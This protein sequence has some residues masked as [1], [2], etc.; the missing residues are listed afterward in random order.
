[1]IYHYN[2]YNT[3]QHHYACIYH[4]IYGKLHG[5]AVGA[6]ISWYPTIISSYGPCLSMVICGQTWAD[7]TTPSIASLILYLVPPT[8]YA[9]LGWKIFGLYN[10]IAQVY[11]LSAVNC[12]ITRHS[13][14][15]TGYL[16]R[17][18]PNEIYLFWQKIGQTDCVFQIMLS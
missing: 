3:T 1:M 10:I 17:Y 12:Q 8:W 4:G 18:S 13:Q 14:R 6:S 11:R 9:R 16:T 15:I 7:A 2:Q 5:C